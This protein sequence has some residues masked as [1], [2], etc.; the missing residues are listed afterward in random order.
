MQ[1]DGKTAL[2]CAAVSVELFFFCFYQNIQKRK[3]AQIEIQMIEIYTQLQL[4]S[5]QH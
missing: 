1:D 2:R 3:P 5:S 4:L